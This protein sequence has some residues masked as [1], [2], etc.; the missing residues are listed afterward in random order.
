MKKRVGNEDGGDSRETIRLHLEL[1]D[2]SSMHYKLTEPNAWICVR[3]GILFFIQDTYL[4]N[5]CIISL[6]VINYLK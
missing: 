1:M 6:N 3:L 4:P 2:K 5:L